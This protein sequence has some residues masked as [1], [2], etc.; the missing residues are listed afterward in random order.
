MIQIVWLFYRIKNNFYFQKRFSPSNKNNTSLMKYIHKKDCTQYLFLEEEERW[1]MCIQRI[2]W[3]KVKYIPTNRWVDGQTN[4]TRVIAK[5]ITSNLPLSLRQLTAKFVKSEK[6]SENVQEN[7]Y[8][9][10]IYRKTVPMSVC[11][12]VYLSNP[13]PH[14][15]HDMVARNATTHCHTIH[16]PISV[17]VTHSLAIN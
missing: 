14:R 13:L 12:S 5:V 17:T 7:F 11:P 1:R 4:I 10:Y 16:S 9:I 2:K 3:Q 8:F 15:T 6:V